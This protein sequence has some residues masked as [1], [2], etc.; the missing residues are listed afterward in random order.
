MYA[1]MYHD[2]VR[3]KPIE[4][5]SLSG[6]ICRLG[7]A[8]GVPTPTHDMAYACLKPYLRGGGAPAS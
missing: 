6:L 8:Q 4:L 2:L 7:T 1:S 5:D 3:G